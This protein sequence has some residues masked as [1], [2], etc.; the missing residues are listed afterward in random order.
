MLETLATVLLLGTMAAF[1]VCAV[2]VGEG[3]GARRRR[4]REEGVAPA[5]ADDGVVAPEETAAPGRSPAPDRRLPVGEFLFGALFLRGPDPLAFSELAD[6]AA[7]SGMSTSQVLAWIDQAEASGLI[8]RV[9]ED[10]TG[11][12]AL[13]LTQAGIYIA[14]NDHRRA[15]R[16][17]E[18]RPPDAARVARS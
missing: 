16:A 13:R 11:K 10:E 9:G 12:P 1:A 15:R 17:R 18:V 4:R 8:E 5:S 6:A 3:E 2:V 7:G 14:C